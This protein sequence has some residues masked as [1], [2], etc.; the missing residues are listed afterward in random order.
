[1]SEIYFNFQAKQINLQIMQGTSYYKRWRLRRAGEPFP[2]FDDDGNLLWSAAFTIRKVG[3]AT[4]LLIL[5]TGDDAGVFI[6]KDDTDTYYGIKMSPE[7]TSVFDTTKLSYNI[8]FTRLSDGFVIRLHEGHIN[9]L[10]EA[11]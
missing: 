7:I 2:F 10:P 11:I 6:D 5:T 8:K 1:M 3:I 9:V 4:P